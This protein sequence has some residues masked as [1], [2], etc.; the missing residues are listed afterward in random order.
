MTPCLDRELR[1]AEMAGALRDMPDHLLEGAPNLRRFVYRVCTGLDGAFCDA[2]DAEAL[3]IERT[4]R[5]AFSAAQNIKQ[6]IR[7]IGQ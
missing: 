4:R 7:R 5:Q 6:N 3:R 1:L 2:N